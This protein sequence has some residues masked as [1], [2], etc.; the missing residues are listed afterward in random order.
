MSDTQANSPEVTA[1]T[2]T[3]IGAPEPVAAAQSQVPY[4]SVQELMDHNEKMRS[5]IQQYDQLL[6]NAQLGQQSAAPATHSASAVKDIGDIWW[7]NPAQA[8]SQLKSDFDKKV[9]EKLQQKEY[10]RNFWESFYAS[11][12]DLKNFRD[13]VN[14]ISNRNMKSWYD[15]PTDEA[16]KKLAAATRDYI[17]SVRDRMTDGR[18]MP[19][20]GSDVTL[21]A[22]HQEMQMP[23]LSPEDAA[24]VSFVD[25]IKSLR[26][27][28]AMPS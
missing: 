25:Q 1:P 10:E 4:K 19:E 18:T 23:A 15:L 26:R 22:T 24:G 21:G 7:E 17:K 8:V 9:D 12:A 14:T 20:R 3:S 16:A 11:N 28:A 5:Q 6:R 2:I 27:K 13:E